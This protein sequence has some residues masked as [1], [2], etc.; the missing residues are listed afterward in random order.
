[1]ASS[2]TGVFLPAQARDRHPDGLPPRLLLPTSRGG[3][4]HRDAM[5]NAL[6]LLLFAIGLP[7]QACWQDAEARYGIDAR[8]LHAIAQ[9]ESSLN[10]HAVN[11]S[12]I[13]PADSVDIGLMQINSRW[14]PIL[15]RHGIS[16]SD[17]LNPCTNI[18]VG[19]WI[20]AQSFLRHGPTWE[21]VGAYNA[22]CARLPPQTCRAT[23]ARYAMAVYQRLVGMDRRSASQ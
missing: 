23:R 18:Q 14:L 20:L 16:E 22:G 1:M 7:V 15:A 5:Y 10:P 4:L 21:A 9:Q 8:L 13:A 12:Q 11:R 6:G 2:V 19:A 3:F 17:L